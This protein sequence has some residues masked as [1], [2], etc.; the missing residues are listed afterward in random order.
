MA[1]GKFSDGKSINVVAPAGGVVAG[2]MYRISNWNG[3]AS[4]T[5]DA[6][7]TFALQID[8]DAEFIVPLPVA[9]GVAVGQ[10]VYM[11]AAG[12][13]SATDATLTSSSNKAA[14][15]VMSVRDGGGFASVRLLN[16]D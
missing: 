14:M 1:Q 13:T 10:I 4:D 9:V 3:V 2:R 16:Q 6:G 12:G 15:K 5:V 11:P 8:V 7:E